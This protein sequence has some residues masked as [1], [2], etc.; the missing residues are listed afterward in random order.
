MPA[1]LDDD[2]R[3]VIV[4]VMSTIIVV[5][6][7]AVYNAQRIVNQNVFLTTTMKETKAKV[8]K[9]VSVSS[10][11]NNNPNPTL[12]VLVGCLLTLV[13][14]VAASAAIAAPIL[15]HGGTT[16]MH[17]DS[18][19]DHNTHHSQQPF[20]EVSSSINF[21]EMDFLD[22]PWVAE[23]ANTASSVASY[24]PLALLGLFGPP[25]HEWRLQTSHHCRFAISYITLLA[26]GIGSALLHA[27]L[28]DV[29]QGGDE[30]PMLWFTASMSFMCLDIIWNGLSSKTRK[31]QE[32][33]TTMKS[34]NSNNNTNLRLLEWCF[35]ISAVGATLVYVLCRE[36]FLP[37]YI[38]FIS[39]SWITLIGLVMICHVLEW[40]TTTTTTT[41]I[42]TTQTA[43]ASA[44]SFKT[45][46]LLPFAICT[47]LYAIL[48]IT[49]WT[50]E[51]L[52]CKS[53]MSNYYQQQH[54]QDDNDGS[55]WT[56]ALQDILPWFFNRG[57]HLLWHC[58]SALLA[59][60]G[61][62]TLIAAKG[63]QLQWG[64]AQVKWWGAPYV[65]FQGQKTT[66]SL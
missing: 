47:A 51:M 26:I 32:A 30:L 40:N 31:H 37:F 7:G 16:M 5:L 66:K 15:L 52:F 28:T 14:M 45:N 23:P 35:G 49:A 11:A 8:A 59:W 63:T 9:N 56:V 44:A 53:V 55:V 65:S 1:S 54:P 13:L 17:L 27:L 60:L 24:I 50:A 33:S 29:A 39:Y 42:S 46:V 22:H 19:R 38:M 48:A 4:K 18:S 10:S 25:S 34:S 57:V 2:T 41:S 12:Q 21:C 58:S 64:D 62:Q 6:C 3:A 43:A 36:S 20:N 61:I